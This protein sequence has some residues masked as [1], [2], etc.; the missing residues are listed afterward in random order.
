MSISFQ[1]SRISK[2][3]SAVAT[4][5]DAEGNFGGISQAAGFV[6]F[7]CTTSTHRVVVGCGSAL[8][9]ALCVRLAFAADDRWRGTCL[10]PR[11]GLVVRAWDRTAIRENPDPVR[12]NDP[13][14]AALGQRFGNPITISSS[15]TGL[16]D[17]DDV[18]LRGHGVQG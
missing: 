6:H 7:G 4:T 15:K 10:R 14:C 3:H 9:Q 1:I 18:G 11:R 13:C 16:V 17:G 8:N 12:R 2:P 5:V